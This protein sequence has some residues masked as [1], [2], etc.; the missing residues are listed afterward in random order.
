MPYT[1]TNVVF[2]TW[3]ICI[4]PFASTLEPIGRLTFR[5]F[6]GNHFPTFGPI[7]QRII[8]HIWANEV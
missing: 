5:P 4:Y 6:R 2:R 7:A 3:T 1:W 8:L